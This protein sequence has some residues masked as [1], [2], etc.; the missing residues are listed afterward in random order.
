MHFFT[1][2]LH[3]SE[4][5]STFAADLLVTTLKILG[6]FELKIMGLLAVL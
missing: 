5:S 1:K 3:M 2:S 6:V 4:K